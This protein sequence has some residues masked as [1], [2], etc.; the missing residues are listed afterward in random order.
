MRALAL[1][2]SDY[3]DILG[4][5]ERIITIIREELIKIKEEF[6]TPRRTS[7]EAS[8]FEEDIED[9]IQKEDMVITVTM[10]GYIKRVPLATFRAQKRGGKGRAGLSMKDEDVTTQVFV[11]NTHT[12]LMFFSS[13]GMAYRLKAYKLPLGAPQS[14]GRA[15]VNLL[16]LQATET[17]NVI[18]PLPEDESEWKNSDLI[19]STSKGNIRRNKLSDFESVRANGK[20]AMKL[21]GEE[22]LIG[23]AVCNSNQHILLASNNGKALRCPVESVRVFKGRDST[24]VRGIDLEKGDKV[25]S[26]SILNGA[27]GDM[28]T[29][30]EYLKIPAES[31]LPL[32]ESFKAGEKPDVPAFE[33][34]NL[35]SETVTEWLA[36]EEFILTITEN[37]YGKRSSAYE[38]RITNR[39]GKGITNIITSD[40]NGNVAASF[41]VT[42]K[43]QIMLITDKGKLIRC[44]VTDVRISGR[45]TQGVTLFRV[46][47]DEK[48]VSAARIVAEDGE[49]VEDAV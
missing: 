30:E 10:G 45:S 42:D 7:I 38:Y 13:S 8:E 26:M 43:D 15:L 37:G 48:V 31:R 18:L 46:E 14:K 27:E 29:R 17:V 39:G 47:E 1:E 49:E 34:V 35:P 33:G 6:A 20:I 4:S 2:I 12:P 9:L 5:R 24:G 40:R 32:V 11:A 21:D 36:N 25:I 44:P 28:V 23:V 22:D 16:P 3:L 41:P 19:F